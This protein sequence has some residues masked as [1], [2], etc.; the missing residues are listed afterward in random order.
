MFGIQSKIVEIKSAQKKEN[1]IER[2]MWEKKKLQRKNFLDEDAVICAFCADKHY[3]ST[4]TL[5]LLY[6]IYMPQ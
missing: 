1:K 3:G 2:A 5:P 6:L 4:Y